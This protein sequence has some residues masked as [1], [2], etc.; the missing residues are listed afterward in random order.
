MHFAS[1][2]DLI[3]SVQGDARDTQ[4]FAI[5]F[6]L[7]APDARTKW[8]NLQSGLLS[9]RLDPANG[10]NSTGEVTLQAVHVDTRWATASNPNVRLHLSS[11]G[12]ATNPI[13]MLLDASAAAV[14]TPWGKAER[15]HL[16]ARWQQSTTNATPQSGHADLQMDQIATSRGGARSLQFT[17][18][19]LPQSEPPAPD[20]SW[21]WWT[22]LAPFAFDWE[23]HV[24]NL[25]T[26]NLDSAEIVCAGNWNAPELDV[27][28]L[29]ARVY[30]GQLNARA[31]LNVDSRELSFSGSSDFD[32]KK[33]SGLLTPHSREWLAQFS[34]K[35]PPALQAEG[36]LIL[37]A[38]TNPHPEW[39]ANVKP[40]VRLSGHLHADDAAFRGIPVNSAD[41]HFTYSNETWRL[42][43]LVATRPEGRIEIA[44]QSNERTEAYHFKIY[45]TADP[46]ALLP[47]MNPE[48]QR[49]FDLATLS[50][51]PVIDGEIWGYWHEPDRIGA[52]ARVTLTNFAFRGESADSLEAQI[53]YTNR[54]LKILE[55]RLQSGT[56]HLSA[57]S[58][59]IDFDA[60]K[61][62]LTNGYGTA[63][64]GMVTRAIGPHIAR[65]MEPYHCLEPA[66]ARVN[67][68][69]PMKHEE[70]ADL[71]FEIEDGSLQ[72]QWFRSSHVSGKIDWTG[73]FLKLQDMR[74]RF[75][76]G[77]VVGNAAFDF[78]PPK[79]ADMQ[80]EVTA[81]NADLHALANDFGA[82][83]NRLEGLLTARLGVAHAN[84]T[85]WRTCDGG[86]RVLLR[87]GLIW[88]IPVFGILSPIL[89]SIVPGLGNSR[90]SELS[91]TF[92]ITNGMAR[93]S[94]LEVR[95]TGMRL[96]YWGAVDLAG[97][98]D[99][100]AQAE[101]LR[102]A[103]VVGRALSFALWPVT[104][105]L[106]Y[107]ITG[108][109]QHPKSEPV[110]IP[111]LLLMPLHP[112]RS[113][114]GLIPEEPDWSQTNAPPA[115]FGPTLR[116]SGQK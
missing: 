64:M 81:E 62:Y 91:A 56:Q 71:H 46:R 39:R 3:V 13:N 40:T 70:D 95:A 18:N 99:A 66:T 51:P 104:K 79:G 61:I 72:W 97:R 83:T 80:F 92:S 20:T 52:R 90:A 112:F 100:R 109:I 9:A 76:D 16:A 23:T 43:D 24:S 103:W 49:A 93:S 88:D 63:D 74:A 106:E 15:T 57:Q 82:K 14:E 34:W 32:L 73:K 33:I 77:T 45:S 48:Q 59:G 87:N 11:N 111:K 86:G 21:A 17:A 28:Q 69:I 35:T 54:F 116:N 7:Q 102:D 89:D 27:T 94:D 38:W 22:N 36:S 29:L 78:R 65:I 68:V 67:G 8:G 113:I 101:P 1:P 107:K 41:S 25:Q 5:Q 115:L 50:Q 19:F 58:L 30:G 114:K 37:P 2:P 98:V 108:T 31:A 26:S 10:K 96:A 55:P 85:D 4:S 42:P 6:Q 110:F 53:E 105:V 60:L 12:S 44:H 47:L 84:T 75:Y